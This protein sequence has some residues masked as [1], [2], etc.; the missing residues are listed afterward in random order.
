MSDLIER[1]AAIKAIEKMKDSSGKGDIAGFYNTI[2]DNVIDKLK[3]LP[4]AQPEPMWTP[5]IEDEELPEN[6]YVLIS[7]KPTKISG[8]KWCVAIA[9][10]TADPR[11]GKIQW[12][13]SG[14]GV[15]PD[16]KVLAWMPRPKPY[17]EERDGDQDTN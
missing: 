6:E 1:R 17:E 2:I 13:D 12:R 14:F 5:V 4:P 8:S 15:I 7:K 3:N 9:I 10:R 16:D 11:S